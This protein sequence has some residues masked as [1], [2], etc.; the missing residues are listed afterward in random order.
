LNSAFARNPQLGPAGIP[1]RAACVAQPTGAVALQFAGVHPR[2]EAKSDLL[3]K[4]DLIASDLT[5]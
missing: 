2:S 3:C 5:R 1:V 4:S